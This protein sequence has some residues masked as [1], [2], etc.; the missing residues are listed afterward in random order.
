MNYIIDT[1]PNIFIYSKNNLIGTFQNNFSVREIRTQNDT[2]LKVKTPSIDPSIIDCLYNFNGNFDIYM[3]YLARRCDNGREVIIC[4]KYNNSTLMR[5]EY[6][7]I[8][9]KPTVFL[10]EFITNNFRQDVHPNDYPR[11]LKDFCNYQG[12][13]PEVI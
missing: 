4:Y 13:Q 12:C 10:Y 1:V 11:E 2:V 6:Q 3:T 7:V 8:P 5:N 9:N